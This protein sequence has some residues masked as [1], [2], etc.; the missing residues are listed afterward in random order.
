MNHCQL[1]IGIYIWSHRTIYGYT[2]DHCK[3]VTIINQVE[4]TTAKQPVVIRGT[5]LFS[6]VAQCTGNTARPDLTGICTIVQ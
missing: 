1:N 3:P 4:A 5:G 6:R 2:T